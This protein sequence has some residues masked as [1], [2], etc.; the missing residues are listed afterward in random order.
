[1]RFT[2]SDLLRAISISLLLY[3]RQP[4]SARLFPQE[5]PHFFALACAMK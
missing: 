3:K 2:S 5:K 1:L 4:A